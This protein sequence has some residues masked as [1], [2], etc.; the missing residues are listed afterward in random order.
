[1]IHKMPC[2]R[3]DDRVMRPIAYMGALKIVGSPCIATPT[4]NFPDILM[5][6]CS[7]RY[8]DCAYKIWSSYLYPLQK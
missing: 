2:Y 5:D 3:K 4:A 6:F 8:R 7:D 1:M